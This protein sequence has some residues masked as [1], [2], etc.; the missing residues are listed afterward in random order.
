MVR[1]AFEGGS[2]EFPRPL[3]LTGTCLLGTLMTGKPSP[4]PF[5]IRCDSPTPLQFLTN[6]TLTVGFVVIS[7]NDFVSA[8]TLTARL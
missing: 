2:L 7:E 4:G 5:Q 1:V 8:L 3:P 6:A